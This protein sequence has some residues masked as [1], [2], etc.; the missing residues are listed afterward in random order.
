MAQKQQGAA[1]ESAEEGE[2]KE[3][4]D[5]DVP[6]LVENFDVEE[7]NRKGREG[8]PLLEELN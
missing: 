4:D 2:T 7:A 6:D 8:A 3:A 1:G 5:E